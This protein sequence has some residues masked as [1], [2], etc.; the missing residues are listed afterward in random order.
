MKYPLSCTSNASSRTAREPAAFGARLVSVSS[1][2]R[3]TALLDIVWLSDGTENAPQGVRGGWQRC[4][5]GAE[6][7]VP[8]GS[9]S[10]E[11]GTY[12]RVVVEPGETILSLSCGGGGYG[13]PEERGPRPGAGR[14]RR[15]AG[16]DHRRSAPYAVYGV[17]IGGDGQVDETGTANRRAEVASEAQDGS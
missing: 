16:V 15:P 5:R 6:E 10:D 3:S 12:A 17:E 13:P 8:D 2:V 9:L 1:S 11:L 4:H 7:A 14:A